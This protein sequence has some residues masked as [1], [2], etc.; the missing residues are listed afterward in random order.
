MGTLYDARCE[1]CGHRWQ[2]VTDG[3]FAFYQVVCDMCGVVEARPRAAPPSRHG[4]M[5]RSDLR[6]YVAASDG[7]WP[8]DGRTFDAEEVRLIAELFRHCGCGGRWVDEDDP[9]AR[10]RCP[11][12]LSL[13]VDKGS[14]QALVD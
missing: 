10:L 14:P 12:C 13:R 2:H 3:G 4:T 6:R 9:R 7:S 1:D 11:D 8:I 5:T